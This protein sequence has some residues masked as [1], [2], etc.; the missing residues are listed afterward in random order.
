MPRQPGPRDQRPEPEVISAPSTDQRACLTPRLGT[1]IGFDTETTLI[2]GLEIPPLVLASASDSN[3]HCV[4]PA[5]QVGS[6]L[7]V[8][9]DADVVCHNTAFDFLWIG[10]CGAL[11]MGTQ[12]PCG[13]IWWTGAACTTRC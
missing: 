7:R 11:T 9:K 3:T 6:F 1:T 12:R 4:I 8:H 5:D 13:G 2:Q 10:I